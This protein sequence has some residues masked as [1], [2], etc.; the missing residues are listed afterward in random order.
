MEKRSSMGRESTRAVRRTVWIPF[1]ASAGLSA[2][3]CHIGTAQAWWVRASPATC[4]LDMEES[5]RTTRV[6][7]YGPSS[8]GNWDS[9]LP[10]VLECPVPDDSNLPKTEIVATHVEVMD[11]NTATGVSA[12]ACV[13]FWA[14]DGGAC[15][16]SVGSSIGGTGHFRL[17]LP[18]VTS[19]WGSAHALD[20]GYV[21]VVLP[22][23]TTN[24]PSAVTGLW[25]SST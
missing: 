5:F 7:I 8:I 24:T 17:D 20:F 23:L 16:S 3:L 10:A 19:V 1:L 22:Q 13:Q 21:Y 25:F 9:T 12:V 11:H 18:G 2:V 6:G 4:F 14:A 15:S